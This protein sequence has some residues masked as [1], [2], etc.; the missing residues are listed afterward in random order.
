MLTKDMTRAQ[1]QTESILLSWTCSYQN[2][3][4]LCLPSLCL[5][6]TVADPIIFCSYMCTE[7]HN[8]GFDT[9]E[10]IVLK[11]RGYF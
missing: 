7:V 10:T 5:G 4:R 9:F 2:P 6:P 3:F 11:G 8:F 1:G